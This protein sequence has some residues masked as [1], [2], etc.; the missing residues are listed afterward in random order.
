[1]RRAVRAGL[2]RQRPTSR[3]RNRRP[4]RSCPGSSLLAIDKGARSPIVDAI[5]CGRHR[6]QRRN[7]EPPPEGG[8]L[9]VDGSGSVRGNPLTLAPDRQARPELADPRQSAVG[10]QGELTLA[11]SRATVDGR[12]PRAGNIRRPRP[13]AE[14]RKPRSGA[15]SGLGRAADRWARCRH[16]GGQRHAPVATMRDLPWTDCRPTGGGAKFGVGVRADISGSQ[17]RIDGR[18]ARA[19]ARPDRIVAGTGGTWR[20]HRTASCRGN[21]RRSRKSARGPR[22]V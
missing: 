18:I 21:S 6:S 13:H 9:A 8:G 15:P 22:R 10:I 12:T 14:H 3:L 20:R 17:A 5:E 2:P 19:D 4:R 1:M 7:I 16:S 11:G